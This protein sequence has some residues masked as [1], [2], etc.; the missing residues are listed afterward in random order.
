MPRVLNRK[1]IIVHPRRLSAIPLAICLG[2][3]DKKPPINARVDSTNV[4]IDRN[5]NSLMNGYSILKN[6]IVFK[7]EIVMKQT[8]DPSQT[9]R[10]PSDPLIDSIREMKNTN[11]TGADNKFSI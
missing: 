7:K 4:T 2:S 3:R 1:Y 10:H 5:V 6:R 11:G 9:N 8:S